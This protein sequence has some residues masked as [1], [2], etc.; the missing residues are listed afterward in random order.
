MTNPVNLSASGQRT[1]GRGEEQYFY[2]TLYAI[3]FR[4][5][6]YERVVK[7]KGTKQYMSPIIRQYRLG[8]RS[9]VRSS[10]LLTVDMPCST[11]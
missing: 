7:H 9:M 10:P 5:I 4:L 6:T 2:V 11:F 1:K 3:S 8:P